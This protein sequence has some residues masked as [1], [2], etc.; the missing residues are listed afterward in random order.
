MGFCDDR[1]MLLID[2]FNV[3]F[4]NKGN[5]LLMH[6]LLNHNWLDHIVVNILMMLMNHVNV[7]LHYYVFM[8]FMDN[9][10]VNLFYS[11]LRSFWRDCNI[12][13]FLGV[14][15]SFAICRLS[16]LNNIFI[17]FLVIV[18][19]FIFDA[20]TLLIRAVISAISAIAFALDQ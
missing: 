14:L 10:F 5:M 13:D 3:P 6:M 19:H 15:H 11:C 2:Y 20:F 9:L 17:S 12:Y 18:E 4:M 16:I 1:H 7:M 8:M